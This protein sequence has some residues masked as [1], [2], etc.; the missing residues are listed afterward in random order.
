MKKLVFFAVVFV[1]YFHSYSGISAGNGQEDNAFIVDLLLNMTLLGSEWVLWLLI[2]LSVWSFSL[3]AERYNFF[4][5]EKSDAEGLILKIDENLK[6]GNVPEAISL[7]ENKNNFEEKISFEALRCIN[8][9]YQSVEKAASSL[10]EIEGIKLE[11][12]LNFLGTLGNNAPFIGLFGTCLGII[13][14]FNE[15]AANPGGGPQVV[16]G[17][18]SEALVATAVGLFVAIPAVVAFNAFHAKIDEKKSN[19]NAITNMII[20][21]SI[22]QTEEV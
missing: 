6:L 8:Q 12:G 21:H 3:I 18:I 9:G 22:S 19:A 20:K 2:L 7:V 10:T 14:A 16:M 13:Q 15:L 4:R 5:K 11:K 1:F 17:G